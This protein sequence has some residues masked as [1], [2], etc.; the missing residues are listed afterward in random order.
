MITIRQT[1]YSSKEIELLMSAFYR[2][3]LTEDFQQYCMHFSTECSGCEIKHLCKE[4]FR[5]LSYLTNV[6]NKKLDESL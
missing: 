5:V 3:T 1:K 6:L 2:M 4:N